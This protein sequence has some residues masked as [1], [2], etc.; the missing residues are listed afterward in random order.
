MQ[1]GGV[2]KFLKEKENYIFCIREVSEA[3]C[4]AECIALTYHEFLLG[5]IYLG[6]VGWIESGT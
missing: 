6:W 4:L 5:G 3:L 2:M 1:S